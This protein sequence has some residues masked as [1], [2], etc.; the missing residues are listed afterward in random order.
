MDCN[1]SV[2]TL[3]PHLPKNGKKFGESHIICKLLEI[4]NNIFLKNMKFW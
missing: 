1:I 2:P 3:H 4:L